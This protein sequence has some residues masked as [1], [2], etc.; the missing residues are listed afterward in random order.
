[1]RGYVQQF[2]S[3]GDEEQQPPPWKPNSRGKNVLFLP[4]TLRDLTEKPIARHDGRRGIRRRIM[5]LFPRTEFHFVTA[6]AP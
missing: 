4:P 2:H 1:M 5:E 6:Y 3:M